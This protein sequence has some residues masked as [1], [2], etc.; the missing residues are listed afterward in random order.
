MENLTGILVQRETLTFDSIFDPVHRLVTDADNDEV[1]CRWARGF[2]ECGHIC[3][4]SGLRYGGMQNV[5]STFSLVLSHQK[6]LLDGRYLL[7]M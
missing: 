4:D 2:S 1:R 5:R 3:G 6:G 7:H